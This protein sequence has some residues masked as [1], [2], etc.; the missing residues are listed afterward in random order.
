MDAEHAR[1]RLT[2]ER[3]RLEQQLVTLEPEDD[4]ELSHLDQHP[5]DGG[6]QMFEQERDAGIRRRLQQEIEAIGR[7]ERRLDEGT[8]GTSVESGEPIPDGRLEAVP[9]SE[10]TAEEQERYDNQG[11]NGG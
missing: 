11:I 3:Q 9:W 2:E 1:R 7:A 10:R 4:G 8:Y 5:G 6:T